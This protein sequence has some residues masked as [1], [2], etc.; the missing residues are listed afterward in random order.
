L[1][2]VF[3]TGQK[4][5]FDILKATTGVSF[6]PLQSVSCSLLG[7]ITVYHHVFLHYTTIPHMYA[8]CHIIPYNILE[9]YKFVLWNSVSIKWLTIYLGYYITHIYV[10]SYSIFMEKDEHFVSRHKQN[11][12]IGLHIYLTRK[13]QINISLSQKQCFWCNI[14]FKLNSL[15]HLDR[16]EI[17]GYWTGT[18]N[19]L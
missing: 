8:T 16:S 12:V 2:Q 11:W 1:R 3:S 17:Q 19:Y 13:F 6:D 5:M 10:Q 14:S 4:N 18:L 9:K 7:N 15:I